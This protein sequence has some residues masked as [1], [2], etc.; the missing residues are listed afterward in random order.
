[1]DS[2]RKG[3]LFKVGD[4]WVLYQP[5]IE[6]LVALNETGKMVWELL[7]EGYGQHE[8][9]S[10][11]AKHFDLPVERALADVKDVVAGLDG[12]GR[13]APPSCSLG[14]DV[15]GDVLPQVANEPA[16]QPG[17]LKHGGTFRFGNHCIRVQWHGILADFAN[18]YFS[19]FHHRAIDG[20]ADA[21]DL[22]LSGYPGRFSLGL[23]GKADEFMVSLTEVFGRISE[24]LLAWE[25]PGIDFIAYFH[26]GAVSRGGR[27]IL[28]PGASGAG[29]S[30]L[31]AYLAR[32]GFAYLGDDIVAMATGDWSLRPLPTRLSLKSGAWSVL[33]LYYPE[34]PRLTT[35]HC[36]GRDVRYVEPKHTK[37]SGEA[38]SAILFPAYA[39]GVG[40]P[41][42][43]QLTPF[44]TMIRL[45]DAITDLEQPATEA[46]LSEF[47]RFVE[48]T[49]AYELSYAGLA[50][51]KALIEALLDDAD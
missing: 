50:D 40:D 47:I 7:G 30:T 26:A 38:P 39:K 19:R 36:H 28:L 17:L 51:A 44:Q 20:V 9:A 15:D 46:K 29:K 13:A 1:M 48:Q 16:M 3:K 33:D 27:S 35:V 6:R 31:T 2:M 4:G 11:F 37:D 18:I 14:V 24:L 5:D 23:R 49:P 45:L 41:C 32:H 12:N 21:K 42:L 10:A 8:I 25:H 43:I 22:E 34:L